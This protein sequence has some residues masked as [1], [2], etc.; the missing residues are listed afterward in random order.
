MSLIVS[1]LFHLKVP[2]VSKSH[3]NIHSDLLHL[4]QV[5]A[6]ISS[7]VSDVWNVKRAGSEMEHGAIISPAIHQPGV[8]A[9]MTADGVEEI[10]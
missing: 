10:W 2:A 1:D 9:E 5:C 7:K 3:G 6:V 8:T 4:T